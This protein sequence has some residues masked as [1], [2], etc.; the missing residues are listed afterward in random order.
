MRMSELT[1]IAFRKLTSLLHH[2][3]YLFNHICQEEKT[4]NRIASMNQALLIVY[5]LGHLSTQFSRDFSC[6]LSCV[7]WLKYFPHFRHLN[8][9]SPVCVLMWLLSVVEPLNVRPQY[10]HLNG[11]SLTWSTTWLR[12]SSGFENEAGHWPHWK[13]FSGDLSQTCICNATRWVKVCSHCPHR[14]W[15]VSFNELRAKYSFACT[16]PTC[17]IKSNT[18]EHQWAL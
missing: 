12:S 2:C 6:L 1:R 14:H 18:S 13:G 5:W 11:L 7:D 10:P 17:N 15:F 9:R 16:S 4:A 8:G 3:M